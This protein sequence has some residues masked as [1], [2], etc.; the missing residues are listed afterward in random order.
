VAQVENVSWRDPCSVSKILAGFLLVR[1]LPQVV[2]GGSTLTGAVA[3]GAYSCLVRAV[4]FGT[5]LRERL[6]AVSRQ[7]G[8]G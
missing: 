8:H 2:S 7:R 1:S 3:F 6:T 5:T 4:P